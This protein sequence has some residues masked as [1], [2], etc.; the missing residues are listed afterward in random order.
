MGPTRLAGLEAGLQ[1]NPRLGGRGCGEE[2][3]GDHGHSSS[4]ARAM[5]MAWSHGATDR[6]ACH[7]AGISHVALYDYIKKNP[8]KRIPYFGKGLKIPAKTIERWIAQLRKEGKI[9]FK[10]SPKTGGYWVV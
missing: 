3:K 9:E 7:V 2:R 10:G 4:A 1:E 6:Q 8:G 5:K